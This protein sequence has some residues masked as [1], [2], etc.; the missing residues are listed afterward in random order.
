M[1]KWKK[2]NWAKFY[3]ITYEFWYKNLGYIV[4]TQT[5]QNQSKSKQSQ[6][7]AQKWQRFDLFYKPW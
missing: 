6:P 3:C 2:L 4:G 5:W 7:I 1:Q